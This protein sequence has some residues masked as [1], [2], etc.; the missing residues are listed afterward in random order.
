MRRLLFA[1]LILLTLSVPTT[2]DA[3]Y[4][5]KKAIWGPTQVNGVSQFPIYHDLGAGIYQMAVRWD[6]VAPTRPQHPGDPTDPAYR[7]PAEVDYAIREGRRYGI[8]VALM[9][10]QTPPWANGARSSEWAPRKPQD[11]AAFARAAARRYPRV[12]HWMIWGEPSRDNNFKPLPR[13]EATG[14]RRYARIL[15]AAYRSLKRQRG[16]NL[17]I[18]GNTFTTGDI[19]PRQFIRSMRLPNG[20]PPRMDLYGHNPFTRRRPALRKG[21]LG[22][23]YAD[24]SDLDTLARWIDR[25][26]GLSP[27]G[28]RVGLFLS[29]F[30]LPTDHANHEFNFWVTREVQARWLGAAMRIARRWRRIYSFGWFELYDQRPND[31]RGAPGDEVNRGLLEWDGDR[32]PSYGAFKRG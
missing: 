16:R 15:D 27:G 3:R 7:W 17:V 20:R 22:H 18:G 2:A 26:L 5:R 32:K 21:P 31:P 13:F 29:E 4:S 24:F 10:T 9:L 12:R 23:G 30:T 1:A 28:K 11:F 25:D 8:R 14:P 6:Q 19:S